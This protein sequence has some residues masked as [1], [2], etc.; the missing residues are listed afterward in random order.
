MA[1][2]DED[3]ADLPSGLQGRNT[4]KIKAPPV[5]DDTPDGMLGFCRFYE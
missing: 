2:E 5:G 4:D 1:M 3:S